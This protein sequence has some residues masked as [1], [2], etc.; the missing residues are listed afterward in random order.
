[1]GST[2]L[3]PSFSRHKPRN[4]VMCIKQGRLNRVDRSSILRTIGTERE[5][6]ECGAATRGM[7]LGWSK[8]RKRGRKNKRNWNNSME[9]IIEAFHEL[10]SL[11]NWI[12]L[13]QLSLFFNIVWKEGYRR[14]DADKFIGRVCIFLLSI[15]GPSISQTAARQICLSRYNSSV[16]SNSPKRSTNSSYTE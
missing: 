12:N 15:R 1:M 6:G 11:I 10:Y 7:P 3:L 5:R 13:P 4:Y 2:T 14:S 16:R 8:K 9:S